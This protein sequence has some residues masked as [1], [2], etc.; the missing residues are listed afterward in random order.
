MNNELK[1]ILWVEGNCMIHSNYQ[2]EASEY[3]LN[4]VSYDC[5]DDAYQAL[6][7]DFL[8]WSAIIM[9]PK[10]KLHP[11]SIRKVTQFLPQAFS[12]INVLCATKGKTL[13]WY[14]LTDIHGSEFCDM[15]LEARQTWDIG[16]PNKYYNSSIDEERLMLFKRIKEQSQLNERLQIKT[17]QYKKVFDALEFLYGHHLNSKIGKIIEDLL[18][19]TCFGNG[20]TSDLGVLR[21]VLEYIFHSMVMN[22]LL[23]KDLK[24]VNNRINNNSCSRMLGGMDVDNCSSHYRVILPIMNKMMSRNL[25]NLLKLGNCGSHATNDEDNRY[26]DEYLQEIGTNN[27]LNS[28]ALQLCDIILWYEKIVRDAQKQIAERGKVIEWWKADQV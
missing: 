26:L 20:D 9:Q 1:Q 14:L 4:L 22:D 27:L 11:G 28:C 16:W 21:D 15:V 24:N 17:G 10:S 18:V 5:W 19:S 8:K 7:D 25:Y 12:D 23:P 3:G 2:Q 13:P 6:C